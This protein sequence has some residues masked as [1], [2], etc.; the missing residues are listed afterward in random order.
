M[1]G[2]NYERTCVLLR[3]D[4][5]FDGSGVNQ[6]GIS[7]F[8][9]LSQESIVEVGDLRWNWQD[10]VWSSCPPLE[11]VIPEVPDNPV[12]QSEDVESPNELSSTWRAPM[13]HQGLGEPQ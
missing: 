3:V 9:S 10:K 7:V 1:Y 11:L 4:G 2:I 5:G 6:R 13:I 8:L 12:T